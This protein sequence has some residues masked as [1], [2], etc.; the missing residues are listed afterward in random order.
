MSIIIDGNSGI[1][2]AGGTPIV[3]TTS[4]PSS[5]GTVTSITSIGN[6]SVTGVG[7]GIA[8]PDASLQ[9]TVGYTG[10][11]NRIINGAMVIDQRNSGASGTASNYTVDRWGYGATQASKG[12]WGRNLNSVT[13]PAGFTNYLGFQSSS[14][15]SVGASDVFYI[16]QGIEGYNYADLAYGTVNAKTT[17]FSFWVYSSLTGVFGGAYQNSGG[18]RT[19][20]FSYTIPAANTWTYITVTIPGDTTGTWNTTNGAA[21]YVNF[22]LGAGST[23]SG[24]ANAWSG[25]FYWQP[26][27]STS[28]VGTSGAT[29]YITGVQL[30][31][32]S[33][34]TPFEFRQF[35]TELALCQRYFETS[36]PIGTA[37][38]NSSASAS[39]YNGTELSSVGLYVAVCLKVSKRATPS[40][41]I[42]S[43]NNAASPTANQLQF[44]NNAG[45]GWTN[46]TG[47]TAAATND[48]SFYVSATTSGTTAGYS[49]FTTF[50]WTASAE[51]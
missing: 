39:N 6:V 24:S 17:T 42:Y 31:K 29:F 44:Y 48:N 37:P 2:T 34:A 13:P 19:Y 43:G 45:S 51:L 1:S 3:N 5:L 46:T 50:G 11:R 32:G 27:G 7:S 33:V 41:V 47:A 25:S 10:F 9:T 15:Y 22:S 4:N 16:Y 14:A 26:T 8:Y 12:T 28:V 20:P 40:V 30:E 21:N 18:S 23:Y 36:F 49:Y 38:A 35:G